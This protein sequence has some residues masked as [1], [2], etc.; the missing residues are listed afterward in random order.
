M[1]TSAPRRVGSAAARA[2]AAHRLAPRIITSRRLESVEGSN[3]FSLCTQLSDK[4]GAV[5]LGQG[6]PSWPTPAFVAELGE[7]A[8]RD[9]VNQYARPG[10]CPAFVN[11]VG[12]FYSR[13][14]GRTLDGMQHVCATAG[15]TGALFTIF[16]A[17][18]DPGD[19]IVCLEPSYDAYGKMAAMVGATV[20]GV[21]LRAP[22]GR[23]PASAQELVVDMA[24]LEGALSE[25]TRL[26]VLNTP[27]N[28]T[29]KVFSRAEY[30]G[31]AQL[32]RRFP[33][34]L[35]VSDE[36]YELTL[37]RGLEHVRFAT[38]PEMWERTVSV[39]SAGKTFSCTGWRVGYT[40]APEA[41]TAALL[42]AQSIQA[43]SNAAPLELAVGRALELAEHNSYLQ[44]LPLLL[45]RKRDAL[46]QA[47]ALAGLP[48]ILSGGGYF[49]L[50]DTANL[51][52]PNEHELRSGPD[53]PLEQR[54]DFAATSF[55]ATQVGVTPI[56]TAGFY[57]PRS[58]HLADNVLR[59]AYCKTDEE[60]AEA[61]S[62]LARVSYAPEASGVAGGGTRASAAAR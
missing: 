20:T 4:A 58:R 40:V 53:A 55:L 48:P 30:E 50:C 11:T 45:E 23:V 35:V 9:G 41:I 46:A 24:E 7:G 28:P 39:Y 31:I 18:C 36:V 8:I 34:L 13:R 26:L 5:N 1:L 19:E 29:G 49:L 51:P 33:Q 27:H 16:S 47:L 21:P 3:I 44:D 52:L 12:R 59:F 2:R 57:S 62:R 42:K 56:P 43:H 54:R 38:L 32:V 22:H 25:R 14:F 60:I 6:F 37:V 15:A 17:L 10:G 61:A